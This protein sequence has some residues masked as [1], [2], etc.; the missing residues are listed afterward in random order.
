MFKGYSF[1]RDAPAVN[2]HLFSLVHQLQQLLN[3]CFLAYLFGLCHDMYI[4]LGK[5][6]FM[7]RLRIALVFLIL[8][9]TPFISESLLGNTPVTMAI[10]QKC[11]SIFTN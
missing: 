11:L 5:S 8:T 10:F 3:F 2:I 1:P 9:I 6:L 4:Q 7:G